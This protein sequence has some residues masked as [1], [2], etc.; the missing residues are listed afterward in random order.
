MGEIASGTM[1]EG[2]AR[3]GP[4]VKALASEL[5]SRSC[6]IVTV[7]EGIYCTKLD[8]CPDKSIA[9]KVI[10]SI[11]MSRSNSI[12]YEIR[13]GS[14]LKEAKYLIEAVLNRG[15]CSRDGKDDKKWIRDG[16]YLNAVEYS[17]YLDKPGKFQKDIGLQIYKEKKPELR[18]G[19]SF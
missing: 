6:L 8:D 15:W 4:N 19:Q 17:I 13:L 5:E 3:L 12:P 10:R 18:N 9:T 14:N 2:K 16:D 1:I 7:R 11:T